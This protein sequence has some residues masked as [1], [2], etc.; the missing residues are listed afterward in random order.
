MPRASFDLTRIEEVRA[1]WHLTNL[2]LLWA[3]DNRRKG[4]RVESIL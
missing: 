4:A 2:R 3:E 1:C